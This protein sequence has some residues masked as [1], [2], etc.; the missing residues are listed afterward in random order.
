MALKWMRRSSAAGILLGGILG[1]IYLVAVVVDPARGGAGASRGVGQ[2]ATTG[3]A[4]TLDAP[5]E[6]SPME[7]VKI[8]SAT[9]VERLRVSG[10]L[11]PIHQA[12]LRAK[13]GGR[14]VQITV[15]EG[16]V[17]KAGD[18]LV[19]F[20]SEDLRST[21]K[22]READRDGATA[23]MR[24]A[25]QSLDRIEQLALKRIASQEQLDRARSEVAAVKARRD[26]LS[27]QMEMAHTALRDAEVNAPFDGVVSKLAVNQ[28]SRV[29][30]DA[31]LL[32]VVDPD[33]L[34]ARVLV[35][36][37]DAPR[38]AAGQPVELRIDGLEERAVAGSVAR[39]GPVADSGT[40]FVPV[41]VVVSNDG[42]SLRGGMFATG[43]IQV[44]QSKDAVVV[45]VT[46]LRRDATGD[47]VLKLEKG[48]LV[49][50]PVA[51]ISKWGGG[52]S[53]EVSGVARG[54]EIISVPLTELRPNVA[55]T[56]SKAG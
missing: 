20:E 16:Q 6:L 30:A 15:R 28:G 46:S 17:V 42:G 45:P 25:I 22:Q 8:Q 2:V 18:V 51:I 49:R 31:E 24:F 34:E 55:V 47:Y 56:I 44:R 14:I 10:E 3:I 40:R 11:Q 33:V 43:V 21:L 35:S 36:T 9:L 7:I 12:T 54:D 4:Y 27:A 38:V 52:E 37:R 5:L 23:Q 41:F 29:G 19:R 32:T 26:G 13:A 39:I 48:R 53:V 1:G 50:Q